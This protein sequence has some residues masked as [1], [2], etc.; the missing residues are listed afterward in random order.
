MTM[1]VKRPYRSSVRE[2]S[3]RQTRAHIR[4]AATRLFIDQGYAITT[5]RQVAA[6]ADVSERTV[7]AVFPTKLDLFAEAIGVAMAGDDRPVPIAERPEFRAALEEQ[8]GER[9]LELVVGAD[10]VT[11]T[12][13][14]LDHVGVRIC[15]C[16][17]RAPGG[18]ETRR[19]SPGPGLDA[20]GR[21]AGRPRCP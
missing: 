7:Y 2:K 10:G 9:A 17:R 11:R 12:R 3:A 21:G 16:R 5:M 1:P 19:A 15:R 18:S 8:D 13:W 20:D 14:A 6:E 4:D